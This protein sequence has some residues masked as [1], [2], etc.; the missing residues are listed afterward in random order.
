MNHYH[1]SSVELLRWLGENV[2]SSNIHTESH[3]KWIILIRVLLNYW[4]DLEKMSHHLTLLANHIRNESLSP[5]FCWTIE[6]TLTKIFHHPTLLAN[7][8]RNESLSREFCW[9]IEVTWRKCPTIEHSYRI[10][11]EM[12][13]LKQSSVQLFHL[14]SQNFDCK[15]PLERYTIK[16]ETKQT[17]RSTIKVTGRIHSI[18][19]DIHYI[20]Y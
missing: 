7:H 5:Q 3:L 12:N 16:G 20:S 8:I 6:M 1:H 15:P 18:I 19:I 17:K 2:P 4:G 13:Y 11:L 14:S 10:T 9:T